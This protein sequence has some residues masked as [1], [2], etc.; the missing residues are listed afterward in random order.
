MYLKAIFLDRDGTLNELVKHKDGY[1][2]PYYAKDLKFYPYVFDCLKKLQDSGYSLFLISNQ[3]A[4]AKGKL[5]VRELSKIYRKFHEI[6][7]ENNIHFKQYYY[8][9]HH[10]LA[11]CNCR[12]P[13][14][15]FI[16]LAKEKYNIDINNSWIIGDQ[17]SDIICGQSAGIKTI[18]I[19]NPISKLM[20]GK[21][22][23]DY[24]VKDLQGAVEIICQ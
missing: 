7:K 22:N 1:G 20:R 12:K 15:F 8:C 5:S 9:Y 11:D 2:S 21:S 6:M 14:P 19:E 23:P 16:L 3:A 24:K 13:K 4:Y 10:P 17:D 18:L